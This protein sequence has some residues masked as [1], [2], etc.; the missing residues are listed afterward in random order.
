MSKA[1][2]NCG[3]LGARC[4]DSRTPSGTLPCVPEAICRRR[5]KCPTCGEKFT[6]Y[7]VT[8][9]QFSLLAEKGGQ[10]ERVQRAVANAIAALMKVT[11]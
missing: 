2:S 10:H 6:T 7:E 5:Y 1:C 9:E 4:L 3:S 11:E 8:A